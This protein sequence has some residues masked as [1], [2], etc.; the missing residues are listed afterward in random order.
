MLKMLAE[1]NE[2]LQNIDDQY[3]DHPWFQGIDQKGL[4]FKPG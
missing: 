4:S 2:E 3:T 1:I